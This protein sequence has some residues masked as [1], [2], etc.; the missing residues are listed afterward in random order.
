[1][2]AVLLTDQ[3]ISD[4]KGYTVHVCGYVGAHVR[5]PL[6]QHHVDIEVSA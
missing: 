2:I 4:V 5:N 3:S 1:M 6:S